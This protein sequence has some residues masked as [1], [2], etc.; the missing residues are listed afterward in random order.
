MI[1]KLTEKDIRA[2]KLGAVA[3]VVILLF[4]V[5]TEWRDRSSKAK[6]NN[7]KL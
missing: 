4:V 5:G 7:A 3:A 6:E 2:L 1:D